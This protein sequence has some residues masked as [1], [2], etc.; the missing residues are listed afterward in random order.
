LYS[1]FIKKYFQRIILH[2]EFYHEISEMPD[3][4]LE[5]FFIQPVSKQFWYYLP[6]LRFRKTEAANCTDLQDMSLYT[7]RIFWCISNG[8]SLL[9]PQNNTLQTEILSRSFPEVCQP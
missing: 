6:S 3:E 5:W 1:A 4:M 8:C 9:L 2:F 7:L